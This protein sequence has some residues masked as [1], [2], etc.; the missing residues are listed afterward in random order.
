MKKLN[1]SKLLK[2]GRDN[3]TFKQVFQ[4]IA[5]LKW[6]KFFVADFLTALANLWINLFYWSLMSFQKIIFNY[7][8]SYVVLL[9][10]LVGYQSQNFKIDK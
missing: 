7:L 6:D 3:N 5:G 8:T 2:I 9:I 10:Q 1:E 4:Q